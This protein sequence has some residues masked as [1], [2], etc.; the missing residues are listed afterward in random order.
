MADGVDG[1]GT[2]CGSFPVTSFD[3]CVVKHGPGI[4]SSPCNEW[5]GYTL[6]P[7]DKK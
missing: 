7:K 5:R 1:R 4:I 2:G 3:A 6:Q